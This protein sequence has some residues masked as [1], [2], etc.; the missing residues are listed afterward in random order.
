MDEPLILVEREGRVG[1]VRLNRPRVLNA[2]N[3]SLMKELADVLEEMDRDENIGCIILTGQ[4][5]AFAAGADISEMADAAPFQFVGNAYFAD[6]QRVRRVEKPLIAAVAGYALGGGN[7]LAMCCDIIIA[8]ETARFG[9]PEI[10]LGV[11]PGAGGTQRLTRSVGKGKAMEM[12]LTGDP[13]TAEEA[14]DWGLINRVVP[15][16]QLEPEALSLAQKI[17]EKPPLAVKM[18]KQAI[19]RAQEMS[20]EQGLHFEQLAFGMLFSTEDQREGMNAFIEKR[21]AQFKGK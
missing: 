18:A 9:Q 15:P 5:K 1:I 16:E 17:A 19:L 2:L 13:I 3:T 14:L 11:I 7:E 6:W 20:L 4:G 12:I 8:A 10:L 21:K